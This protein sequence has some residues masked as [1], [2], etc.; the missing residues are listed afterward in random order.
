MANG[1][2][3]LGIKLKQYDDGIEIEGGAF[4]GGSVDAKGDHRCAMSFIIASLRA[5]ESIK[6]MNTKQIS[7]SFPS[8]LKLVNSLGLNV[9]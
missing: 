2:R 6:I 7:T 5:S 1:L 4:T 3:E 9:R 8:F